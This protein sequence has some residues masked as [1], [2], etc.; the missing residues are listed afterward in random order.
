[1]AKQTET[2]AP[3]RLNCNTILDGRF[4]KAGD[5]LPCASEAD[6]PETLRPFIVTDVAEADEEPNEARGSFQMGELYEMTPDGRLGR[7]L[8]RKVERQVA[9]FEAENWREEQLEQAAADA[10]LPP[11]VAQD[12]QEAHEGSVSFAQAQLAADAA[13]ADAVSDA[14]QEAEALPVLLVKRGGRHYTPALKARLRANEDVYI[15]QPDGTFQFI[16]TTDARAE[17]PDLPITL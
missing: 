16:G 5:P 10:E 12:L 15:R 2:P 13:R 14:A 4:I 9:E 7:S 11:E 6:V 1:M 17:L 8:R 3:I